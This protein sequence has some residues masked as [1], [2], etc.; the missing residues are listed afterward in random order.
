[1]ALTQ[2]SHAAHL[3]APFRRPRSSLVPLELDSQHL[4]SGEHLPGDPEC[5]F[6]PYQ[7]RSRH[8][9][10]HAGAFVQF[11]GAAEVCPGFGQGAVVLSLGESGDCQVGITTHLMCQCRMTS[12]PGVLTLESNAGLLLHAIC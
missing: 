4:D 11:L 8:L 5:P 10:C 12:A 3:W 1:M 9:G 2:S 6:R 7:A